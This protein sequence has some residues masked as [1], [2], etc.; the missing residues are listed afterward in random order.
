MVHQVIKPKKI[1]ATVTLSPRR[2][3]EL[4][5]GYGYSAYWFGRF[6][7]ESPTTMLLETHGR[8]RS[9]T[10]RCDLAD[11]EDATDP[12]PTVMPRPGTGRPSTLT[13]RL[14]TRLTT[15]GR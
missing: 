11:C 4:G 6:S 7:W 10:V 15:P 2:V 8:K 1:A 9:A 3:M 12:E 5:S 14:T 13:T